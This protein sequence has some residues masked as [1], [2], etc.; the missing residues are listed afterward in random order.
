MGED[1]YSLEDKIRIGER[2]TCTN[3]CTKEE[4][5]TLLNTK[6]RP[7]SIQRNRGRRVCGMSTEGK[8]RAQ[9]LILI[10]HSLHNHR[11][12]CTRLCSND[13][14]KH[15]TRRLLTLLYSPILTLPFFPPFQFLSFFFFITSVFPLPL[16]LFSLSLS[17]PTHLQ[18]F[19]FH[20]RLQLRITLDVQIGRTVK[21]TSDA[22]D[23]LQW[24]VYL[25]EENRQKPIKRT[26]EGNKKWTNR[27]TAD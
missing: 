19:L 6:R 2:R 26:E 27:H 17:P 25:W 9:I 12:A 21:Y 14:Q 11:Y 8:T 18:S 16:S 1:S 7:C 13:R 22:P 23:S 20:L 3:I 4:S 10:Q 15:S 24:I 5:C